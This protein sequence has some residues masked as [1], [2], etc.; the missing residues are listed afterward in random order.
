MNRPKLWLHAGL[1]KTGTTA[2]QRFAATHRAA[3]LERGLWYP[4]FRPV[5]EESP[6]SHNRLAHALAGPDKPGRLSTGQ[7]ETLTRHWHEQAGDRSL[8]IS[9]EA[10]CR[11]IDPRGGRDWYDQR[12]GYLERLAEVLSGFEVEVVLVLRRQDDFA[13]SVYLENIMKASKRGRMSF[14]E[15]RDYL[16]KRHLRYEDNIAAFRERFPRLKIL[17]YEAIAA[18]KRLCGNFFA[19]LGWDVT[20]LREPGRI[21]DSLSVPQARTKRAMLPLTLLPGQN[22]L[23]NRFLK[24]RPVEGALHRIMAGS[25]NGFWE[26]ERARAEWRRAYAAENERLRRCFFPER[27]ALFPA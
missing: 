12:V 20:D 22:R 9:A 21:R 8:L 23:L 27:T 25:P 6:P 16:R 24:W 18:D 7:I 4:D 5:L 11:H 3:L 2:I 13:H 19:E 15:F 1:H 26:S 10:L 14:P 17:T